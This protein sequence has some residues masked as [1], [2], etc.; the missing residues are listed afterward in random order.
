MKKLMVKLFN[1]I[2][3]AGAAIAI[4]AFCTQPVIDLSVKVDLDSDQVADKLEPLINKDGDNKAKYRI[5]YREEAEEES[6][7][8][9]S[10]SVIKVDREMIKEAFPDGFQ[11]DV[12]VKIPAS[13]AFN[14]DNKELLTDL[15][16]D[17]IE[18][19]I[20]SVV[21]TVTDALYELI[22]K[23]TEKFAKDELKKQIQN[24]I[25]KYFEDASAVSDQEVTD[26]YN[27]VHTKLDGDDAVSVNELADTIVGS[28]DEPGTILYIL[29]QRKYKY[30][31][32]DPQPTRE[33]V[34]EDAAK[35]DGSED[36]LYYVP[37][38]DGYARATEYTETVYYERKETT[39]T[40]YV[41]W[42]PQPTQA[43]VEADID[44]LDE[45]Q[46]KYYIKDG[47]D[48]ILPI[49]YDSDESYYKKSYDATD[50][51]GEM[52][53]GKL[54]EALTAMPGL[55]DVGYSKASPTEEEF[56]AAVGYGYYIKQ[57]SDGYIRSPY[58]FGFGGEYYS[59]HYTEIVPTK[60]E[61]EADVI[62]KDATCEYFTLSG[63]NYVRATKYDEN[64]T[65]YLRT[66]TLEHPIA[67]EYNA[68]KKNYKYY[69]QVGDAY[70]LAP[71]TYDSEAQYYVY[72]TF[73]ND[74]DTA[75]SNLIS[76]ML[77]DNS[78]SNSSNEETPN[79]EF[80]MS[81]RA[82][83]E[84]SK[85]EIEK[86]LRD[87]L[88]KMIPFDRVYEATKVAD[89]Y[90]VYALAGLVALFAFPWVIF[91]LLTLVRTLK[92]QKCWTKPSI[93]I[94]LA[95]PQLILGIVLTYGMKYLMPFLGDKIEIVN[96]INQSLTLG[97][98]TGCLI[99]SFVYCGVFILTIP[100]IF[101]ARPLK[102][103]YKFEKRYARMVRFEQKERMRGG[104]QPKQP[105]YG[106]QPMY[107]AEQKKGRQ[108]RQPKLPR[109]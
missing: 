77:G 55:V 38:G 106:S 102:V 45:S 96:T 19:A 37:S 54:A 27:N 30:E 80:R 44:M 73:V 82:G 88:N 67:D 49:E 36:I 22:N 25:D 75:L 52:I 93:V 66:F 56:N 3:L 14:F 2:Y 103:E 59:D 18:N 13:G 60:E 97:V 26:L 33:Q 12:S 83:G 43:E 20:T 74:I 79:T 63:G 105:L 109:N 92:R 86:A 61:I 91:A 108:P 87:F 35:P 42:D 70:E 7:D 84:K 76:Q 65:Y 21:P 1:L 8:S 98:R 4:Y 39:V 100:Y 78:S 95:F 72:G 71:K 50:V 68:T 90:A 51:N 17:N 58:E 53:A 94:V 101:F 5:S 47:D 62:K 40:K 81:V 69:I 104:R 46:K 89:Q 9:S 6:S 29:E 32:W 85:E 15:T 57:G 34:E 24:E 99:P 64:T 23:A 41:L 11:L 107:M 31:P 28:A 16:H 10:S 48:Y